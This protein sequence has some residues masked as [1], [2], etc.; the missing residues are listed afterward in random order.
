[1][2]LS[3]LDF[4][5]TINES[6]L[7]LGITS[8]NLYNI[9]KLKYRTSSTLVGSN[10]NI[11]QNDIW[12]TLSNSNGNV[13]N[14]DYTASNLQLSI[15]STSDGD[16]LGSTGI[17]T[18]I[19]NGV[20]SNFDSVSEVIVL[21]GTTQKLS[22]NNFQSVNSLQVLSYGSNKSAAGNIY[23]NASN[24]SNLHCAIDINDSGIFP[25][26]YTIPRGFTGYLDSV[27]LSC[28][29]SD[30]VEIGVFAS[31]PSLP[32]Q[33]KG[34]IFLYQNSF[35]GASTS[36]APL[37]EKFTIIYAAK[38]LTNNLTKTSVSQRILLVRNGEII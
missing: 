12:H 17:S 34:S 37:P 18:V 36:F 5:Q 27:N 26:R 4:L 3:N 22:T 14:Y 30:N 35:S 8:S 21:T 2:R 15:T 25:G 19:V 6:L 20:N 7:N 32:L 11:D 1:M 10:L 38:R 24:N 9:E 28:T 13:Y 29:T 16:R 33:R 31:S 23:F